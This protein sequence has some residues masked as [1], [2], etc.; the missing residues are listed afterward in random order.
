MVGA[1]TRL[2]S[3]LEADK[4]LDVTERYK[5][6]K[7]GVTTPVKRN[8]TIDEAKRN[9]AKWTEFRIRPR[10]TEGT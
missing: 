3:D 1:P 2:E 5:N 7:T 10:T 8:M 6:W 4:K 9:Q